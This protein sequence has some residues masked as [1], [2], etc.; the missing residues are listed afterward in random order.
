MKFTSVVLVV[1]LCVTSAL[2]GSDGF[3]RAKL[4]K[5]W[6]ATSG[7]LA[8]SQGQMVGTGNLPLGYLKASKNDSGAT[9]VV[10]LTG[11]SQYG[12]VALGNIAL[13]NNAFVK[14]QQQ[15]GSGMFEYGGFYT[16]DNNPTGGTFF[17]LSSPVPSPAVLDVFF[18]GTTATMRIISAG[19]IQT[20]THN[21][22]TTFPKGAGLGM[23]GQTAIDNYVGFPSGCYDVPQAI[24]ASLMPSAMDLSLAK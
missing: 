3:N 10:F 5:T 23:W 2:A 20:Y 13:G 15:N 18:C 17:A 12:A 6:V 22:G 7:S 24:P 1:L 14:I 9:A 4:G 21:Y 16:G 19:G 8:V 11:N